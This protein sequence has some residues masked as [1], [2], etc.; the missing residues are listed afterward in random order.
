MKIPQRQCQLLFP[1]EHK[2]EREVTGRHRTDRQPISPQLSP[3]CCQPVVCRTLEGQTAESTLHVATALRDGAVMASQRTLVDVWTHEK[4]VSPGKD[5][6]PPR[7]KSLWSSTATAPTLA[8]ASI[9]A[10]RVPGGGAGAVETPRSVG[11]AV[12]THVTTSGQR[13]LIDIWQ[14][15]R[16]ASV[17]QWVSRSSQLSNRW[18]TYLHTLSHLCHSAGNHGDNS[19]GTSRRH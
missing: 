15:Q 6:C 9:G 8:C 10:E 11:A 13:T 2:V 19:T 1:N 18:K 14:E 4:L 16:K 7:A 3:L 5:R 17:H 12:G